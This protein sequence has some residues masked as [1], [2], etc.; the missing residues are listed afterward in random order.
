MKP[1]KSI[2]IVGITRFLCLIF[3]LFMIGMAIYICDQ[4]SRKQFEPIYSPDHKSMIVPSINTDK[5]DM[6]KYQCIKISIID[7]MSGNILFE[8]QTSV[9]NRMRWSIRW[10]ENGFI[11]LDSS[12]IGPVCWHDDNGLWASS[13]CP[14]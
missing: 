4:V 14:K 2:R 13:D 3:Y 1:F 8:Q 9:S 7:T 10:S 12:D 6:T 11:I 5:S